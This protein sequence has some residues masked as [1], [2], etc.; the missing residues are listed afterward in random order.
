M[1]IIPIILCGGSGVRLNLKNNKDTPKQF[2]DFGNWT[3]FDKTL[4]RIHLSKFSSPIISTNKNYLK[5][6]RFFLKK[7]NFKNYKII[8]EPIKKN[9]APAILTSALLKDIPLNQPLIFFSADHLIGKL[10]IFNKSI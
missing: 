7:H 9:T 10:R 2:I 6:I 5:K 4:E 1:K 3:L 8:L